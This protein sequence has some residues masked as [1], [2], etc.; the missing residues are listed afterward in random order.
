MARVGAMMAP[1]IAMLGEQSPG[2]I[3]TWYLTG[4][5]NKNKTLNFDIVQNVRKRSNLE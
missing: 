5:F 3:K 1:F 4:D 2:R